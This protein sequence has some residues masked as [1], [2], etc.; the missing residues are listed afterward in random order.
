MNWYLK[1]LRQYVD[2]SGRAR[3]KEYWMFTLFN[4]II[5]FLIGFVG[6]IILLAVGVDGP[7]Y[8]SA[9][10]GIGAIYNLAILLPALGV[11]VRRLHDIG[12]SGW[13]IFIALI[14]LIGA[15]ILLL[16]LIRD[17][18]PGSNQ[19]GPNPK[20]HYPDVPKEMLQDPAAAN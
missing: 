2:F 18:E 20:T 15:I 4:L 3:R 6:G 16:F 19:Y 8:D 9:I 14:P 1:C 10:N 11:L 13:W 7:E 17:S 12:K 5:A